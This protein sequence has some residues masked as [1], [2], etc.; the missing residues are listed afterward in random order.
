LERGGEDITE[1]QWAQKEKEKVMKGEN[2]TTGA[3]YKVQ[4]K[5][6]KEWGGERKQTNQ[7]GYFGRKEKKIHIRS[8]HE[9]KES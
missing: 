1:R 8:I 2:L 5:K 4:V 6:K 9:K 3:W 7:P